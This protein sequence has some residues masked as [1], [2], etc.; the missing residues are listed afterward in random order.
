[1][2][3]RVVMIV[4]AIALSVASAQA[5]DKD[6]RAPAAKSGTDRG[7]AKVKKEFQQRIRNKNSSERAGA[8]KLLEDRPTPDAADLVCVTL[9]DDRDAAVRQAAVEFLAELRDKPEVADK[10]L[11][12]L[13]T[14]TQKE[15]MDVRALE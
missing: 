12:R 1:M 10:L 8:L 13:T 6:T 2:G 3:C 5:R 9:L 15:G 4:A 11:R 7:F 14:H